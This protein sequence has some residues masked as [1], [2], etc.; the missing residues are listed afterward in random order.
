MISVRLLE[1]IVPT[2]LA[3]WDDTGIVDALFQASQQLF[4][5][6]SYIA[7]SLVFSDTLSVAMQVRIHVSTVN[8]RLAKISRGLCDLRWIFTNPLVEGKQPL[9]NR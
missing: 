8:Y 2:P 9:Y 7:N 1:A 3:L 6:P 4:D 5:R